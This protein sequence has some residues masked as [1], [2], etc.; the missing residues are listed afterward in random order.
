[1]HTGVWMVSI[2]AQASPS[3]RAS[4][5]PASAIA[6]LGPGLRRDDGNNNIEA[7]LQVLPRDLQR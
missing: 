1:M 7:N 5:D 2:R 4:W 6:R 3:S